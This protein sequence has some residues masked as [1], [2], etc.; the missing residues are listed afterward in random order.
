M[1]LKIILIFLNIFIKNLIFFLYILKINKYIIY[2]MYF[3]GVLL[4]LFVVGIFGEL[5]VGI[6]CLWKKILVLVL[7]VLINKN[8][9]VNNCIYMLNVIIV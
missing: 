3:Y 7:I 5:F 2:N 4:W 9:Y 6:D 8:N 1:F